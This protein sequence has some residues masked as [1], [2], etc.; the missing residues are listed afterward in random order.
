MAK[1]PPEDP[2]D[3]VLITN[4]AAPAATPG[5]VSREAYELLYKDKGWKIE[6]VGTYARQADVD[7]QPDE[8]TPPAGRP[9][10][11]EAAK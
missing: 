11:K 9:A 5:T 6:S 7:A 1:T 8:D 10:G 4:P 2:A 3:L